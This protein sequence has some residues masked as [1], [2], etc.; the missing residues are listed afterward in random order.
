MLPAPTIPTVMNETP[1][2]EKAPSLASA[3]STA[4]VDS[5]S[6]SFE[7]LYQQLRRGFRLFLGDEVTAVGDLHQPEVGRLCPGSVVNLAKNS[8]GCGTSSNGSFS[9]AFG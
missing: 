1:S 6:R 9:V 2:H 4:L 8:S 5:K 3:S 7:E